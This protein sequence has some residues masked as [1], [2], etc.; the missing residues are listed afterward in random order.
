MP[1]INPANV[2]LPAYTAMRF[3]IQV[4]RAAANLPQTAAAGIAVVT[5][6]RV[7]VLA[8]MGQVTTIIQ[9]Q[10][11]TTKLTMVPTTGAS[12][13][14]CAV[15]DINGL[16]VGNFL[17]PTGLPSDALVILGAARIP[18]EQIVLPIGQLNLNCA[19]SS[20][21]QIKWDF[22]WLPLDVGAALNFL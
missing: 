13:D 6:G 22:W 15:A 20:T 9:A 10:A 3:G 8:I 2:D 7:A 1:A 16:V 11:N 18:R 14:L 12:T 19:A 5:G 21:G 17:Q 4:S